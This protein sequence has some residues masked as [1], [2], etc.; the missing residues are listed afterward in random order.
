MRLVDASKVPSLQTLK[1]LSR[2]LFQ[3]LLRFYF[4][5]AISLKTFASRK[6]GA[7]GKIVFFPYSTP[8]CVL[9]HSL[10]AGVMRSNGYDAKVLRRKEISPSVEDPFL[11]M[12]RRDVETSEP[13]SDYRSLFRELERVAGGNPWIARG[14]IDDFLK[15]AP[16]RNLTTSRKLPNNLKSLVEKTVEKTRQTLGEATHV[17]LSDSA[18]LRNQAIISEALRKSAR[19]FVLNPDGR[20]VQITETRNESFEVVDFRATLHDLERNPGKINRAEAFFE[21]R[22][23]PSDSFA[24]SPDQKQFESSDSSDRRKILFLHVFRDANLI[25]ISKSLGR[26]YSPFKT[27]LEWTDF[28]FSIISENPEEWEIRPHAASRYYSGEKDILDYLLKRHNLNNIRLSRAS[29]TASILA[30]GMP[31]FTHSGTVALEAASFGN[32][33]VTCVGTLPDELARKAL[34][35]EDLAS[36]LRQPV[37]E[38]CYPKLSA[39]AMKVAKFLLH[40]RFEPSS[41]VF[42]PEPRQ[43]NRDSQRSF[44]T[45]EIKQQ[46]SYFQSV[47]QGIRFAQSTFMEAIE[48]DDR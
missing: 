21:R 4:P 14:L 43:P 1:F 23:S 19:V 37:Q 7:R 34:T 25:P 27:Y 6:L 36:L 22:F 46:L 2:L 33:P 8:A 17:V 3:F 39:E 42:V 30:S 32:Q 45:S 47:G 41:R 48:Q 24:N 9:Q 38:L 44:R 11:A 15:K 29:S 40:A 28:C 12:S 5:L 31:V 10:I 16:T 13:H 26:W 18:Y 35:H 20:F